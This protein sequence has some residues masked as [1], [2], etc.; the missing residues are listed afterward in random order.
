MLIAASNSQPNIAGVREQQPA[1]SL[2]GEPFPYR[3]PFS[4]YASHAAKTHSVSELLDQDQQPPDKATSH[5]FNAS[6]AQRQFLQA[7]I[8]ITGNTLLA[9]APA[10]SNAMSAA[11]G[12]WLLLCPTARRDREANAPS[13]CVYPSRAV[14]PRTFLSRNLQYLCTCVKRGLLFVFNPSPRRQRSAGRTVAH[15]LRKFHFTK[16]F[17]DAYRITRPSYGGLP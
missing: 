14:G 13:Y 7:S 17:N 12:N 2:I 15:Q 6:A 10:K 3:Q 11:S 16:Q 1:S 8:S 9:I 5:T 4:G